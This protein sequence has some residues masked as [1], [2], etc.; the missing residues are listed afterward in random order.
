MLYEH[1]N[2]WFVVPILPEKILLIFE[3][4]VIEKAVTVKVFILA[5]ASWL[6]AI[7]SLNL[8][9][10]TGMVYSWVVEVNVTVSIRTFETL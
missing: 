9:V 8:S 1:N 10:L 5:A 6:N 7:S 2:K 3:S 4:V